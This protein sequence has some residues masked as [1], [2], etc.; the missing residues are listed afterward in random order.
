[1]DAATYARPIDQ[2]QAVDFIRMLDPT[3][4]GEFQKQVYNNAT[5][6]VAAYPGTVQDAFT[7]A[8][9]YRGVA[10]ATR[11]APTPSVFT[12]AAHQRAPAPTR[13]RGNN[14]GRRGGRGRA[15]RNNANVRPPR[16]CFRCGDPGHFARDC[17]NN[18]TPPN[19][20]SE[21]AAMALSDDVILMAG[22]TNLNTYDV[23]LDNQASV[24]IFREPKLLKNIRR[25]ERP[26]S[27]SG[28]NSTLV[29]DLVGDT[30]YFETVKYC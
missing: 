13:G 4:Y 6:G 18:V 16:Q 15:T 14:R 10:R 12:A 29:V 11:P 9:Q 17:T 8:S 22:R 21:L 20:N 7:A 5:M 24:S 26:V 3:R 19:N 2:D 27:I 30:D 25:A 28:I 1:M 23:L